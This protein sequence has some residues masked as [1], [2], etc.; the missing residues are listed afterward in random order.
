[1]ARVESGAGEAGSSEGHGEVEDPAPR[2]RAQW[3]PLPVNF[4]F[5]SVIV[6]MSRRL[7]RLHH[8]DP[9]DDRCPHPDG[10]VDVELASD[11]GD[12]LSDVRDPSSGCIG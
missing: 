3:L 10:R 6:D 9:N 11:R 12:T 5:P 1:M 4:A 2:R 7:V 8:R